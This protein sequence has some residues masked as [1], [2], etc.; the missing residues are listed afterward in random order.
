M[1]IINFIEVVLFTE[2][3]KFEILEKFRHSRDLK[4]LECIQVE[5]HFRKSH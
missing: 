4:T 1:A 5:I 3:Q 2:D